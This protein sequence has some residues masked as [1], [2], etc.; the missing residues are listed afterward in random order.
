[1]RRIVTGNEVNL[2]P[3][4]Y[5]ALRLMVAHAGNVLTHRFLLE[6]IW[7]GDADVQYLRVYIRALRQ[8]IEADPGW[9][10]S[11]PR[12]HEFDGKYPLAHEAIFRAPARRRH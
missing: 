11:S 4:E 9:R 5:E 1:V 7:G 2:S 8:K 12:C 6:E 3:R 10:T